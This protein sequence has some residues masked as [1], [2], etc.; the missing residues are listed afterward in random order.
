VIRCVVVSRVCNLHGTGNE[1]Q[2]AV[3]LREV[4]TTTSSA[5]ITVQQH[6]HAYISWLFSGCYSFILTT[7][8]CACVPL[9]TVPCTFCRVLP[10]LTVLRVWDWLLLEG[11]DVLIFVAL[12]V[13]RFA[14]DAVLQVYIQYTILY[15][16]T[17]CILPVSLHSSH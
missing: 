1:T 17:V 5:A 12:A 10:P 9:R 4:Y 13:L 8:V 11:A 6:R 16:C 7:I 14:E 15:C 2:H 3:V